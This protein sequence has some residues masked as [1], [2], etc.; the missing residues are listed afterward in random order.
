MSCP[1]QHR[2]R[3]ASAAGPDLADLADRVG[4]IEMPG[5]VVANPSVHELLSIV[6]TTW[7]SVSS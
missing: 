2:S 5:V 1:H 7:S 4:L 3:R 6:L